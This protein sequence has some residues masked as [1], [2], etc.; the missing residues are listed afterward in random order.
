MNSSVLLTTSDA[1]NLEHYFTCGALR[2]CKNE[3]SQSSSFWRDADVEAIKSSLPSERD[4]FVDL[5]C[6]PGLYAKA[7]SPSFRVSYLVDISKQML[8]S[9]G[10]NLSG[11]SGLEYALIQGDLYDLRFAASSISFVLATGAS[12]CYGLRALEDL[13]TKLYNELKCG[14][15]MY[16]EVWNKSGLLVCSHMGHY[17]FSSLR[18]STRNLD[19]NRINE[20]MN[21]GII[22][23]RF[24]GQ[25]V[26]VTAYSVDWVIDTLEAIGYKLIKYFGR[27]AAALFF[28]PRK[29]DRL[30]AERSRDLLRL[31]HLLSEDTE[32]I[33]VCPKVVFVVER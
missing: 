24:C 33:K 10:E 3:L 12:M 32:I 20:F 21:D 31:E 28:S 26:P 25:A 5:G 29:L 23:E 17:Q 18:G 13:L 15:R 9:A 1:K 27:K 11:Q 19:I 7:L 14:G 2:Y 8:K 4:V 30:I 22:E 16:F 6:G